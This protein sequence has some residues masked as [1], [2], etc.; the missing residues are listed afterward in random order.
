MPKFRVGRALKK[1]LSKDKKQ[2]KRIA[3]VSRVVASILPEVKI[4]STSVQ[5]NLTT[6]TANGTFLDLT[7]NII[8]GAD[9][10]QRQGRQISVVELVFV[11]YMVHKTDNTVQ[12]QNIT[13][14]MIIQDFAYNNATTSATEPLLFERSP[15]TFGK[16][17]SEYNSDAVIMKRGGSMISKDKKGKK[18][19]ILSDKKSQMQA[20]GPSATNGNPYASNPRYMVHRINRWKRPLQVNYLGDAANESGPG[21]IIA[22]WNNFNETADVTGSPFMH[23]YYHIKY[24]DT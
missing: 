6:F 17:F 15:A 2:D 21:Q 10:N 20:W 18:L 12:A 4:Y 5:T 23:Y 3:K 24:I 11:A 13:R 8:Q 22:Y 16:L 7:P 19:K 1:Y 9:Y 14:T